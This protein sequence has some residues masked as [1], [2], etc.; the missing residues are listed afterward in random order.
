MTQCQ[1]GANDNFDRRTRQRNDSFQGEFVHKQDGEGASMARS[2][3]ELRLESERTRAALAATVDQ[4]RERISD[5]AEDLRQKVSPQHIKS[6]VADYIGQT[7][8]GWLGALQQR[9]MDNPLQAVAAGTAVAVPLLRL[10]RGTPLPLLMIAAGL[11]LTSKT[12]RD[13]A[14]EAAAPAMD[15]AGEALNQTVERAQ[16]MAGNIMDTVSS[17]QGQASEMANDAQNSAATI[18]FA[19]CAKPVYPQ[20]DRQAGHQG[21]VTLGFLVDENGQ[22]KDSKVTQST[23]FM[24]LD[25]TAQ[26]ALMK[27]SFRPALE[28]GKPVQKW[29]Y[30][31]YVWTLS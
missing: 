5:T 2:V 25:M 24:R 30:V 10:A 27:C 16:A 7:T 20:A 31:K 19:S 13:R 15:K 4:L 14:V 3:R 9:A 11:A 23:G 1:Q 22:V 12:M 29:A 17:A 6:E 26:T 18:D 21:T 8:Q 28:N